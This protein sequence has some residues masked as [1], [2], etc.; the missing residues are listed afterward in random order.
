MKRQLVRTVD[1]YF[2]I[3]MN[4]SNFKTKEDIERHIDICH[5]II[6]YIQLQLVDNDDIE[7]VQSLYDQYEENVR[8]ILFCEIM[9]NIISEH[10][11][12][13]ELKHIKLVLPKEIK[14]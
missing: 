6:S 14:I 11:E 13:K 2:Q 9:L 1:G 5:T 3:P 7:E 8:E 10:E 12:Q 4:C